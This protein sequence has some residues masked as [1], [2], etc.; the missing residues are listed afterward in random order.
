VPALALGQRERLAAVSVVLG[1]GP[2]SASRG[3]TGRWAGAHHAPVA[4]LENPVRCASAA[5]RWP[6]MASSTSCYAQSL[7]TARSKRDC[8]LTGVI[9]RFAATS[10][11]GVLFSE[12]LY[13]KFGELRG[14]TC[15]Q[16][17]RRRK[18]PDHQ[19]PGPSCPLPNPANRPSPRWRRARPYARPGGA[20][21]RHER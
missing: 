3:V 7:A 5:R 14:F 11:G 17:W 19:R 6:P 8:G 13:R 20:L 21:S 18:G 16:K 10:K 1:A 12:S 2:R 4:L 9:G 15:G